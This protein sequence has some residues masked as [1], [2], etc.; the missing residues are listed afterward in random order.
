[1]ESSGEVDQNPQ[2]RKYEETEEDGEKK[3]EGENVQ[4]NE[5]F[6]IDESGNHKAKKTKSN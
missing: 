3:D 2:K 6:M 4:E 1:M 5:V